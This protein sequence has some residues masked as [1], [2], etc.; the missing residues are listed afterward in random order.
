MSAIIKDRVAAALT[1]TASGRVAVTAPEVRSIVK[2][3]LVDDGKVSEFE[4]TE[5]R[6]QWA[7]IVDQGKPTAAAQ[8]EYAKLSAEFD[9]GLTSPQTH[10]SSVADRVSRFGTLKPGSVQLHRNGSW[11]ITAQPNSH[12]PNARSVKVTYNAGWD[13]GAPLTVKDTDPRAVGR[14]MD[15]A[16]IKELA[17]SLERYIQKH[18]AASAVE[19][20]VLADVRAAWFAETNTTDAKATGPAIAERTLELK[21]HQYIVPGQ[22]ITSGGGSVSVADLQVKLFEQKDGSFLVELRRPDS[23]ESIGVS[24]EATDSK[25]WGT[26]FFGEGVSARVKVVKGRD[27]KATLHVE[28]LRYSNSGNLYFCGNHRISE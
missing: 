5:L 25:A 6:S 20:K 9:I 1:P 11:S 26:P 28:D 8:R 18:P 27:G 12:L 21:S 13:A 19:Q 3:A 24:V 14:N 2:A 16:Q 10:S 22:G 7:R 17:N 4:K 23:D 15:G